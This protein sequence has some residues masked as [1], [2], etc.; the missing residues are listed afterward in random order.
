MDDSFL[1]S[2]SKEHL[3]EILKEI[4]TIA[5]RLGIILNAHKVKILPISKTFSFLQVKYFMTE[6][7][8][9]VKRI[10][11]KRI[12]A[13]RRKIKKLSVMVKSGERNYINV[14]NLFHA[15]SKDFYKLMSKL[16]RQ[17]MD[18]LYKELFSKEEAEYEKSIQ[19]RPRYRQIY[20]NSRS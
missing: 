10:N 1:L 17:N 3:C 5:G 7:G 8:K 14:R 11:P 9:L 15:W 6:S 18:N 19:I 16:Q 2:D 12:T 20:W 4:K 13:M